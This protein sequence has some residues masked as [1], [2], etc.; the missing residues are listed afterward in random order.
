IEELMSDPSRAA[1]VVT[2]PPVA[3]L[4][5]AVLPFINLGRD[6]E[7]EYFSDGLTQELMGALS[8]VQGLRVVAHNSSF[9]YRRTALEVD[10]IARQLK[11]SALMEGTVRQNGNRLRVNV[12]LIDAALGCHIWAERYDRRMED[13]FAV[14][15]EI[16]NTI[17]RELKMKLR[18]EGYGFTKNK[19]KNREAHD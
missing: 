14:Q 9:C 19:T 16:A 2:S 6:P 12:K 5:L 11:V 3:H 10:E 15:E 4:S 17:A 7:N 1:E 8:K 13:I 18:S